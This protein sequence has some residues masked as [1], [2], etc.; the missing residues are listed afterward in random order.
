M[1][2]E[3]WLQALPGLPRLPL[4]TRFLQLTWTIHTAAL[5]IHVYMMKPERK[6]PALAACL[7]YDKQQKILSPSSTLT[8]YIEV[9]DARPTLRWEMPEGT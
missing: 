2:G 4:T 5:L 8:P 9:G 7:H 6:T 1:W 3:A